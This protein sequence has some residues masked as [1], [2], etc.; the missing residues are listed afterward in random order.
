LTDLLTREKDRRSENE[1]TMIVDLRVHRTLPFKQVQ[2]V[3]QAVARA[4]IQRVN[5]VALVETNP[6]D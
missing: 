5:L 4:Q 1:E 6:V 2:P 3:M